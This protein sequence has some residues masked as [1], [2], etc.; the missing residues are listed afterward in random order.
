LRNFAF[1]LFRDSAFLKQPEKLANLLIVR[2]A[3]MLLGLS[4]R[5]QG[6]ANV[7][8]RVTVPSRSDFEVDHWV[9]IID[10]HNATGRLLDI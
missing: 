8:H 2:R 9:W 5:Q 10:A 6:L 3:T 7:F 4:I 1:V